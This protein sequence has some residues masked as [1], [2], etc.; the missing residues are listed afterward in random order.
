MLKLNTGTKLC[1]DSLDKDF[2][3]AVGKPESTK[4]N[5]QWT[6]H[7]NN[8][9]SSKTT[10]KRMKSYTL[11]ENICKSLYHLSDKESVHKIYKELSK[12]N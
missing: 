8:S 10:V 11:R 5:N 2:R 12:N 3:D 7:R 6:I 1:D 9:C 4:E